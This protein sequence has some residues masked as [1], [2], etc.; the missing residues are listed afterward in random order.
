M[1]APDGTTGFPV[2]CDMVTRGGGWTLVAIDGA[3]DVAGA[4]A[5]RP[6]RDAPA[7]GSSPGVGADRQ[8]PGSATKGCFRLR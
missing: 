7:C 5:F 2:W 1:A 4:C 3:L 8:L 6:S